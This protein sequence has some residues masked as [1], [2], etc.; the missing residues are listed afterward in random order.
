[1]LETCR[2]DAD[3]MQ[4]LDAGAQVPDATTLAAH[5]FEQLSAARWYA[6]IGDG[7][8]SNL[9]SGGDRHGVAAINLGTSGAVRLLEEG[10]EVNVPYGLFGYRI[11][12]SRYLVG[13]AV[14]NLASLIQWCWRELDIPESIDELDELLESRTAPDHGLSVLPF[15]LNERAPRWRDDLAGTIFGITQATTSLDIAQ[16]TLESAFHRLALIISALRDTRSIERI[17]VSGGLVTRPS[18]MQRL[19][20]VLNE[21]L[22]ICSVTDASIRGAVAYVLSREAIQI[23]SPEVA[24]RLSP[25]AA[26]SEQFSQHRAHQLELERVSRGRYWSSAYAA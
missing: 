5:G 9:G 6:A 10:T 14:S 16:A 24:Y 13:G 1:M 15:W 3:Q 21:P 4:P 23:S 18:A 11:D 26:L 8:A 17:V 12:E 25:D 7:A 2:V 20:N 22:D 19:S